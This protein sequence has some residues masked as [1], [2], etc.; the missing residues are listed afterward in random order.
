MATSGRCRWQDAS[1]LQSVINCLDPEQM[2]SVKSS[3]GREMEAS[4]AQQDHLDKSPGPKKTRGKYAS[5]AC[6]ECRQRKL[7]CS[8]Q[9]PCQRCLRRGC[10]CAFSDDKSAQEV[11]R[12][13]RQPTT[14]TNIS[15]LDTRVER[16]ENALQALTDR[17]D[18]GES[19]TNVVDEAENNEPSFQSDATLQSPVDQ[20]SE[21]LAHV[22]QQL[23]LNNGITSSP[24]ARTPQ[25]LQH[26]N[27]LTLPPL[28][29]QHSTST[30]CTEIRI[31]SR[32]FPFPSPPQ[33][34]RYLR[35]FFEDINPCHPCVN[36]SHFRVRSEAM[37]SSSQLN[38]RESCFLALHYIMF[39]CSDILQDTSAQQASRTSGSHWYQAADDL[40]GRTRL[41]GHGDLSLIQFLIF[42][43]FWLT[44]EDRPNAAYNTA[45]LACRLCFQ[46]G[47]HQQ[48]RWLHSNDEYQIHMKQRILWTAYFVDRRIALS[49]G[50][51]YSMADRDIAV[52]LPAWL[53]DRKLHPNQPL[54]QPDAETSDLPYLA[55]MVN[56]AKLGGEIWDQMFSAGASKSTP[57]A[58]TIAILDAKIK[59]WADDALP[60]V[61]LIPTSRAPLLRHRRQQVLVYTRVDHL[62]MLLRRQIMVSMDFGAHDGRVC[63]ELAIN[64]IQL[65][66]QHSEE[67]NEPSSFRFHL[68]TSAGGALL[69][70]STLLCRPLNDLG[71]QD[72]YTHYV[73]AFKSGLALLRSLGDG[74][75]AARRMLSDLKDVTAIV[76]RV[77]DQPAPQQMIMN[78]P[79][80]IDNLMPYGAIDFANQPGAGYLDQTY[81]GDLNQPFC[82]PGWD[83]WSAPGHTG[84]GAPWI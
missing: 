17:L 72:F 58:E 8:G 22:K 78:L 15:T 18:S 29:R 53:D 27:S 73:D 23:G 44:H 25:Q 63:G 6:V 77:I 75:N 16:L 60:K 20:F 56:F 21:S 50:R 32:T 5:R 61:P 49:C 7:K 33:Y 65:L 10:R 3:S 45:G 14:E 4:S 79:V 28:R 37:L 2:R 70:L 62:R 46:F 40:V 74:L 48:S 41:T 13:V 57:K 30:G 67:A 83:G 26:T 1:K 52:D 38:R 68:A 43:A 12:S 31:G 55:C 42:E 36:E 59:H 19:N 47:L 9:D 81:A 54:P 24:L 39:A 71:L 34:E 35:F 11:L 69:I 84:Y 64:I 76:E 51:P 82:G 80:D 66:T